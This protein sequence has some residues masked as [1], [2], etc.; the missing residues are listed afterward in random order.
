[1]RPP[2]S[3]TLENV[4][5]ARRKT[6]RE[7]NSAGRAITAQDIVDAVC[8]VPGRNGR[9]LKTTSPDRC[10][11]SSSAEASDEPN[12]PPSSD[13]EA[14]QYTGTP[15]PAKRTR[16]ATTGPGT[17]ITLPDR[18]VMGD[19]R[20]R[21]EDLV[22]IIADELRCGPS[23]QS[24]KNHTVQLSHVADRADREM[25]RRMEIVWGLSGKPDQR[26]HLDQS[27]NMIFLCVEIHTPFDR[28]LCLI[29][30]TRRD[31]AILHMA[32]QNKTLPGRR[33][34]LRRN[35]QGY[36][37]YEDVFERLQDRK[38][39]LIP[40]SN[41]SEETGIQHVTRR[42]DGTVKFELYTPPFLQGPKGKE[43]STLP[44][45]TLRCSPYFAAW[46][47]YCTL[48]EAEPDVTWPDCFDE[49][50]KLVRRIG[51]LIKDSS[52]VNANVFAPTD[53]H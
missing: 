6:L 48:D 25:V 47:A 1:M 10:E 50:V 34:K 44:L 27:S 30:P 26:L 43:R 39:R 22:G 49:D 28:G 20:P 12:H 29:L 35:E 53:S 4:R 19:P 13:A 18:L 52:N 46:K 32:L 31:L 24:G 9:A 15:T 45:F 3:V 17:Y 41:W 42:R 14:D 7:R 37:H 21:A 51:A 38:Y 33:R 2:K 23:G 40:L 5:D 36:I 11:R 16:R 8:V